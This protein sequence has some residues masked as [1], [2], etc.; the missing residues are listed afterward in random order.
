MNRADELA[1][2]ITVARQQLYDANEK[3]NDAERKL[4]ALQQELTD[5]TS[6]FKVG[7][8][9]KIDP[10]PMRPLIW[11]VTRVA[12]GCNNEPRYFGRQLRKDGTPGVVVKSI[13]LWG[14]NKLVAAERPQPKKK[15]G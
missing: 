8:I 4:R 5:I 15:G 3:R 2:E 10:P 6:E 1:L 13:Y 12:P 9:V 14:K 7:D 11:E